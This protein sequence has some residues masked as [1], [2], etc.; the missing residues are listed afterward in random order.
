[1]SLSKRIRRSSRSRCRIVR[2][3]SVLHAFPRST[4][5]EAPTVES[6]YGTNVWDR[7]S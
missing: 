1:M 5:G 7:G 4:S 2:I 6:P 3:S